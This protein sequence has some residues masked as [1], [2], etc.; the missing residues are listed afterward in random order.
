MEEAWRVTAWEAMCQNL[1]DNTMRAG[2]LQAIEVAHSHLTRAADVCG[3]YR[4]ELPYQPAGPGDALPHLP[5]AMEH[6]GTAISCAR[7]VI[8]TAISRQ[9]S[10]SYD[11]GPATSSPSTQHAS[12]RSA[13]RIPRRSRGRGGQATTPMPPTTP[14]WRCKGYSPPGRTARRAA[15]PSSSCSRWPHS[16]CPVPI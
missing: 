1:T 10:A 8:G 2:A 15:T 16:G 7:H 3:S 6:L 12:A 13:S 5:D 9:V 4:Q 11:T 14:P